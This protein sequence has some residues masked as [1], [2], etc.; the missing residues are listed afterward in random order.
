[1]T[2]MII[3]VVVTLLSMVDYHQRCN[4]HPAI[5]PPA[6]SSSLAGKGRGLESASTGLGE[7]DGP[8]PPS[9]PLPPPFL[10]FL[11]HHCRWAILGDENDDRGGARGSSCGGGGDA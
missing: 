5:P 8:I 11:L 7:E 9:H 2:A 3:A 4:N 1:M 6:D 10:L